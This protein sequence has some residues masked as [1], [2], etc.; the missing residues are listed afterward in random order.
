MHF[1]TKKKMHFC[2]RKIGSAGNKTKKSILSLENKKFG[3]SSNWRFVQNS[4]PF[5]NM[6]F[7]V[8][9][10][11]TSTFINVYTEQISP[12]EFLNLLTG[13]ALLPQ[14]QQNGQRIK[15][16]SVD[17][18][19][20]HWSSIRENKNMIDYNLIFSDIYDMTIENLWRKS[21]QLLYLNWSY[22]IMQSRFVSF[23][24]F[25]EFHRV[26]GKFLITKFVRSPTIP[27]K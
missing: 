14:S 9:T 17:M 25:L 20:V 2:W 8:D 15:N 7:T 19:I 16:L 21:T 13:N 11:V 18:H 22:W 3:I 27:F 4:R 6:P 5:T 26:Y 1:Y 23:F 24:L 10:M 12:Y